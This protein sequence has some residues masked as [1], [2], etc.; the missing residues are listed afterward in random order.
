MALP[1]LH[2]FERD[3]KNNPPKGSNAPPRT[4]RAKDLDENFVKV[5]LIES[6]I[7]PPPYRVKYTDDGTMLTDIRGLPEGAIAKEFDVCENGQPRKWW[8]LVWEEEPNV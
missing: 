7:D 6:D 4:V 8:F 2:K 3:L 5:T 1:E